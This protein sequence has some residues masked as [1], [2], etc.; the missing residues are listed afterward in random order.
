[1]SQAQRSRFNLNGQVPNPEVVVTAKRRQFSAA[2]K[3]RI[4]Q[5]AD[6]C[7]QAGQV[8]ALLRREGLYSS[9]LSKWRQQRDAGQLHGLQDQKRDRQTERQASQVVQLQRENERLRRQLHQAELIIEAQKKLSALFGL[10]VTE[11]DERQ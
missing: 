11:P 1:M 2:Y 9:H 4:L 5:E 8:G 6:D 3:L 10:S 7:Q